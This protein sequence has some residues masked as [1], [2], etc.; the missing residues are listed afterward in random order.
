MI[1]QT[2]NYAYIINI[3]IKYVGTIFVQIASK[4]RIKKGLHEPLAI[5]PI[6]SKIGASVACRFQ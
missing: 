2:V 1:K 3:N 4:K 6:S 5:M